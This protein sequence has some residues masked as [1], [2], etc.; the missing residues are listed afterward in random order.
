[1]EKKTALI[2]G[3]N[4]GIGLEACRQLGE[5]GYRVMGTARSKAS[6]DKAMAQLNGAGDISFVQVDI[7]NEKDIAHL[8]AEVASKFGKLNALI[9]N[10]GIFIEKMDAA[11]PEAGLALNA[12]TETIRNVFEV[13]TLGALRTIQALSE[14]LK[15]NE[16]C[17]VNVS[18]GMGSLKDM[19]S[20]W[21]GY[22]LSKAALNALT[23]I[24]SSELSER[25]IKVNSVCPGWVR[26]D[27]GGS[28][29]ARSIP[30][31]ASGLVWAA[32]LPEDGP[33]GGFFRDGKA[34]DW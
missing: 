30:E 19:G 7:T 21:P 14:L 31:G 2:T 33:T 9:N 32:T 15:E 13:N 6:I 20:S 8:K 28:D 16:G 11:N 10:A 23:R 5:K 26:T 1:M 12:S 18:S 24:F 22:R 25:G 4:R 29:A 17:V 27:M 3:A 34:I